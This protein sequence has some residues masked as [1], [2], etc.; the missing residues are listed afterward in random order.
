MLAARAGQC[1][2]AELSRLPARRLAASSSTKRFASS[3]ARSTPSPTTAPISTAWAGHISGAAIWTKRRSISSRG[4]RSC[5]RTPRSRTI[6]AICT[7]ARAACRRRS[8][9]GRARSTATASRHSARRRSRRR[10]VMQKSKCKMQN[11]VQLA[12]FAFRA[13]CIVALA[14]IA[15]LR[16][17]PRHTSDRQPVLP[18][19]ISQPFT[20]RCRRRAAACVRSTPVA[21]ACAD[22][23]ATASAAAASS[24]D[25][26]ARRRCGS[27]AWRRSGS[28][29]S[30]CGTGRKRRAAA[31]AR[32]AR[33]PRSAS[34]G[35]LG[36]LTGVNLAPAD[37]LAILTGC[38]VPDPHADRR[39]AAR[40][41]L[42][43]DRSAGGTARR[44]YLRR[45]TS[46]WEL[47]AAQR[48]GWQIEYTHGAVAVSGVRPAARRI[49]EGR[50]ST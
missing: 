22:A 23:S 37:L 44:C 30:S 15:W 20:S 6:S 19:L 17:S 11:D 8:P 5:P 25:S 7:R 12:V 49:A 28:R 9:R 24:P 45:A 41:R 14:S 2:R 42:G 10:S 31:A 33:A 21:R 34:P 32:R 26:S 46:Q 35:D 16:A 40:Q 48:D 27:R 43:V 39:Q 36:A 13:F 4:G 47:R 38:V 3:A 29:S 18:F 1:Q 50:R